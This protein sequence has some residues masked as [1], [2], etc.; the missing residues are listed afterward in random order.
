LKKAGGAVSCGLGPA[1][2]D[3]RYRQKLEIYQPTPATLKLLATLPDDA[4]VMLRRS[5]M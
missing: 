3:P 1:P 2:F 4:I 5:R